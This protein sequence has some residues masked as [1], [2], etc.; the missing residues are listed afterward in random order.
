MQTHNSFQGIRCGASRRASARAEFTLH[1]LQTLQTFRSPLISQE[2]L[3]C[4]HCP[5]H[6]SFIKSSFIIP[7]ISFDYVVYLCNNSYSYM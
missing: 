3:C 7:L 2:L 1:S 6:S 4:S 5:S